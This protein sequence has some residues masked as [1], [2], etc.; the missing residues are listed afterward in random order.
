[1]KMISAYADNNY[2]GSHRSF[3]VSVQIAL[4]LGTLGKTVYTEKSYLKKPYL[5]MCASRWLNHAVF[6]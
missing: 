4:A 3:M 1:M 6:S 5:H 2:S